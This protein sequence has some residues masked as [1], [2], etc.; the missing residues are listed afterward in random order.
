[1]PS[2]NF[3]FDDAEME[4]IRAAARADD[5]LVEDFDVDR[6]EDLMNDV[7]TRGCDLG[8]LAASLTASAVPSPAA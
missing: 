8:Y 2:L 7:A 6:S 4:Q 5:L 1:M 3:D